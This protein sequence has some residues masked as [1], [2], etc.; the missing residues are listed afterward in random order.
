[1]LHLRMFTGDSEMDDGFSTMLRVGNDLLFKSDNI[2]SM[3][4][5]YQIITIKPPPTY[6][7]CWGLSSHLCCFFFFA[8]NIDSMLS[9]EGWSSSILSSSY[10]TLL[11]LRG[12]PLHV[13]TNN[14][15]HPSPSASYSPPSPS[16]PSPSS[17]SSHLC[18]TRDSLFSSAWA[19]FNRL[20]DTRLQ[21]ELRSLIIR[22]ILLLICSKERN[23]PLGATEEKKLDR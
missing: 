1:M 12:A 7:S 11:N 3:L 5:N 8:K 2:T 20:L 14:H 4:K 23:W 6:E 10:K 18:L 16:S 22:S 17:S 15:H 21:Q 9:W 13:S 19:R